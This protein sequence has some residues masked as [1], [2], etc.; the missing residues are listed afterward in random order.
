MTITMTVD[1]MQYKQSYGQELPSRFAKEVTKAADT[2]GD[3]FISAKEVEKLLENIGAKD[4]LKHEEIEEVMSE[5]GNKQG[6]KGVPIQAVVDYV[7]KS[8]KPGVS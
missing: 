5:I 1:L 7:R 2:D 6:E 4:V 8:S 3:G